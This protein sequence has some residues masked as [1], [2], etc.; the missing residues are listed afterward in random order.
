MCF[1]SARKAIFEIRLV[2]IVVTKKKVVYITF[3]IQFLKFQNAF[4]KKKEKLRRQK[5]NFRTTF[6]L[7]LTLTQANLIKD[8]AFPTENTR[9]NP[10]NH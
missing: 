10:L 2:S 6:F 4:R 5:M 3:K 8:I 7:L 1:F 9:F